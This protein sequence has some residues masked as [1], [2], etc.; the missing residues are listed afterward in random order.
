MG[1]CTH[2]THITPNFARRFLGRRLVAMSGT[3]TLVT[4]NCAPSRTDHMN[5]PAKILARMM[6]TAGAP[7][8][9]DG[10]HSAGLRRYVRRAVVRRVC[11]AR[12]D[13]SA[14]IKRPL[15]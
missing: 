13:V 9:S 15:K 2:P 4:A 5:T 10:L 3:G 1:Y 11:E 14:L 6:G 8:P 7:W 12:D